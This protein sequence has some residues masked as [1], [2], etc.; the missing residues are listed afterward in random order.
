MII[1]LLQVSFCWV[2]FY[3][4]YYLF[5]RR[6]T[7][8]T[9]N[10]WF[11]LSTLLLSFAVPPLGQWIKDLYTTYPI[12]AGHVFYLVSET[13]AYINN[14]VTRNPDI[15]WLAVLIKAIYF[16]GVLLSSIRFCFGL[17]KIYRLYQA[18]YKSEH[19]GYTLVSNDQFHLPFSFFRLV[20]VSNQLRLNGAFEKV[21]RHELTHVKHWHTIDILLTEIIHIFFWFNP[22]VL[23]YRKALQQSHEYHA[24]ACVLKEHQARDYGQLLLDPSSNLEIALVNQFFNSH[25]KNRITMMYQ[26]QSTRSAM[27]KYFAAIPILIL[28]LF[29][30]SNSVIEATIDPIPFKKDVKEAIVKAESK[31]DFSK[32][33]LSIINHY[34]VADQLTDD[35]INKYLLEIFKETGISIHYR[36]EE[37]FHIGSNRYRAQKLGFL[38]H[39][40]RI[41]HVPPIFT[42]LF[43]LTENISGKIPLIRV[44]GNLIFGYW[45]NLDPD[46]IISYEYIPAE[47]AM[48]RF[49]YMAHG[50]VIDFKL[51]DVTLD[52]LDKLGVVIEA[53]NGI[54]PEKNA[55]KNVDT[56]ARFPG[57]EDIS[58]EEARLCGVERFN[59]YIADVMQYPDEAKKLGIEGT[60][61]VRFL[62][63]ERGAIGS[64]KILNDIGGGCAEEAKYLIQSMNTIAEHWTPATKDGK[65]VK[66]IVTLPIKFSLNGEVAKK[67]FSAR[68]ESS[69]EGDIRKP[70]PEVMGNPALTKEM[71]ALLSDFEI[72]PRP[73]FVVDGVIME[74]DS[75]HLRANE[76][77]KANL[78][79]EEAAA[80]KYETVKQRALEIYTKYGPFDVKEDMETTIERPIEKISNPG[81]SNNTFVTDLDIFPNPAK[82]SMHLSF[83]APAGAL[84]I[85]VHDTAGKLLHRES[86]PDFDGKYDK[87]INNS[88]F[89][90]TEAVIS[91]VQKENIQ[92]RKLIFTK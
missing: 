50:G 91:F 55:I 64:P 78:L 77:V 24:D 13:P 35:T 56:P 60:V 34:R 62:V 83:R 66:S 42:K 88:L 22:I 9:I 33:M 69:L 16:S 21:I 51:S 12:D 44:N 54:K 29:L 73:I 1:Y 65:P 52:D 43:D 20:F 87:T 46:K 4:V 92:T 27:V 45:S 36:G 31:R 89:V 10:R 40:D 38:E 28:A 81:I 70:M 58:G 30:F 75:I 76:V 26:K 59:E 61:M 67:E 57:C 14:A 47:E 74:K 19:E 79:D 53:G 7:F 15:D 71:I 84:E 41:N 63:T 82:F 17:R 6:E 5:L 25:L 32:Q 37:K 72:S 2:F 86:I 8:F 11:L 85:R 80:A 68:H 48:K 3:L 39:S 49:G 18:G 90:N 23:L